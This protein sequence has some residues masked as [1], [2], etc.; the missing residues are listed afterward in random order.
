[1]RY[2]LTPVW[3]KVADSAYLICSN[4]LSIHPF[5]TWRQLIWWTAPS[6]ARQSTRTSF[7]AFGTGLL[8]HLLQLDDSYID[9][10]ANSWCQSTLISLVVIQMSSKVA[11]K[12]CNYILLV[13]IFNVDSQ[14]PDTT[15][16]YRANQRLLTTLL[17]PG[18]RFANLAVLTREIRPSK[19]AHI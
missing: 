6:I 7:I 1:M 2:A 16:S 18:H 10:Y 13:H 3:H 5:C 17:T 11:S 15:S 14:S 9:P 8:V 19:D 4:T 12:V